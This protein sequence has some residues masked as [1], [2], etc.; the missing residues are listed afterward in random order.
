MVHPSLILDPPPPLPTTF[1]VRPIDKLPIP[2]F[3]ISYVVHLYPNACKIYNLL[4]Q[5]RDYAITQF[6]VCI[7]IVSIIC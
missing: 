7:V 1:S 3:R 2:I 5:H 6:V 4:M